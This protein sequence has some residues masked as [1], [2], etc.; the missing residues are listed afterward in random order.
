MLRRWLADHCEF[1]LFLREL[2]GLFGGRFRLGMWLVALF[3]T[4]VFL[5]LWLGEAGGVLRPAAGARFR[6]QWTLLGQLLAGCI[7]L[8]GYATTA[9]AAS[10][11][12]ERERQS[13]ELLLLTRLSLVQVVVEKF[14]AVL[15]QSLLLVA[16]CFLLTALAYA[17]G[18]S[19][20]AGLLV[21]W[22]LLVVVGVQLAASAVMCSALISSAAISLGVIWFLWLCLLA[23]PGLLEDV[24][25]LPQWF[26]FRGAGGVLGILPFVH[27]PVGFRVVVTGEGCFEFLLS[28][29]PPLVLSGLMLLVAVEGIRR[30]PGRAFLNP[31]SVRVPRRW[32]ERRLSGWI[33]RL[34]GRRGS[35]ATEDGEV[36]ESRQL[37][38]L[39]PVRWRELARNPQARWYAHVLYCLTVL[40][41]L[42]WLRRQL[43]PL[44]YAA[45]LPVMQAAYGLLSMLMVLV[46]VCESLA[47]EQAQGTRDL[48]WLIPISNGELLRQ[49]LAG[50]DRVLWLL[51]LSN[52]TISLSRMLLDPMSRAVLSWRGVVYQFSGVLLLLLVL[53]L[54]KWLAVWQ[55]LKCEGLLRALSRSLLLVLTIFVLPV[56]PLLVEV[57]RLGGNS[58]VL[59]R[60][61]FLCCGSPL[62]VWLAHVTRLLRWRGGDSVLLLMAVVGLVLWLVVLLCLRRY[63]EGLF[64]SLGGRSDGSSGANCGASAVSVS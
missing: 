19:S 57:L 48:L 7:V 58:F 16:P 28:C 22:L 41:G 38:E 34:R 55:S 42:L 4:V 43:S 2:R 31:Q 63:C 56:L 26:W 21:V 52:V 30:W 61:W 32:L 59:E 5:L 35:A 17:G 40:V 36:R 46:S 47:F 60:R 50:A 20:L 39:N 12:Q 45:S 62:L 25:I 44:E 13:L 6:S 27:V 11:S 15:L 29:V 24:G 8:A 14:A 54:V 18:G 64:G 1:P 49:K 23:I 33:M 3:L 51:M 9:G 10:I 53:H 37:P